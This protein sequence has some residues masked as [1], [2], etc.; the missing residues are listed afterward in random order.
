[1]HD[2]FKIGL[3][4]VVEVVEVRRV[5]CPLYTFDAAAELQLLESGGAGIFDKKRILKHQK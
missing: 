5:D 3:R 2:L 4:Y 1:V